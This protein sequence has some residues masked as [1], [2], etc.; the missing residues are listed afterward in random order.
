MRINIKIGLYFF[1]IGIFLSCGNEPS[2]PDGPT[3]KNGKSKFAFYLLADTTLTIDDVF[4]QPYNT[5]ELSTEPLISTEDIEFYDR[6]SHG[7]YLK[8]KDAT[9]L[10]KVT[11]LI[12][13]H[14]HGPTGHF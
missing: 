5:L 13:Y 7:I 10:P 8:Q 4:G 1:L 14:N 6:S 2:A 9:S 12:F 3:D 11:F